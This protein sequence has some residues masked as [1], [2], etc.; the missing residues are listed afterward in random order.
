MESSGFKE[1]Q[2]L[3]PPA[4]TDQ[5]IFIYL[6]QSGDDASKTPFPSFKILRKDQ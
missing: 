6:R 4:H 5:L 2:G 1:P 3:V